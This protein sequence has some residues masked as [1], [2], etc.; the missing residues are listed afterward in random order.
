MTAIS[1]M[2]VEAR[3][4]GIAPADRQQEPMSR[5][6]AASATLHAGLVALIVFGL[7]SLFRSPPPEETPIAVELVTIAPKTTATHPN[8]YRPKA[9][10]K[11]EPA[12]A[13][14]APKPEPKPEPRVAAAEPPSAATPP[15]P[16]PAPPSPPKPEAKVP[17]PPPPPP[18]PVEAKAPPP[19]PL[20]EPKPKPPSQVARA[21][22]HPETAKA[23]PKAFA[24]L[25][26]HLEDRPQEDKRPQPAAFDAL[27]KNLTKEPTAEAEDAPPAPRRMAAATAA[28]SSQPKAPLG[29]QL[30]ASEKDLIIQ[31]IE[32]CWN[33]PA[34]ARDA[35][36]LVVEIK[37]VVNPDGTVRQATIVDTGRYGSDPFYRAAAD[38]ARRAVLNP[39]CQPLK[40][41][42]DKY[43]L[44]HD[45]DLSF[46]PKDLS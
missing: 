28:P 3:A 24:K 39:A 16:Q 25:I 29:S 14:P 11:P 9:E 40:L 27:L 21:A 5:G 17:P 37:A 30:T 15:P 42:A 43:D 18:K 32:R 44:W 46:N 7:P 1:L 12:P 20:P 19:P 41:P 33:V 38:S 36:D 4:R 22:P 13:P 10:A 26:N 31:Q 6:I 34:G 23:D 2:T 35:G 45:L 8:P